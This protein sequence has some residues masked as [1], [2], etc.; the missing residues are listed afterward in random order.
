MD[1]FVNKKCTYILLGVECAKYMPNCVQNLNLRLTSKQPS[2]RTYKA[3]TVERPDI[4]N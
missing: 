1:T 2:S 4:L 3:G